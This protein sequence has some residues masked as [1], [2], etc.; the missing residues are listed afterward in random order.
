MY[1]D[2]ATFQS[3]AGFVNVETFESYNLLDSVSALPSLGGTFE[4]FSNGS[5]PAGYDQSTGG[6]AHSGNRTLINNDKLALPGLGSIVFNADLN[7]EFSAFGLWNTGGDDTVRLSIFDVN[8]ILLAST[9]SVLGE[10]FIGITGLSGGVKAE[11][12]AVIGNGWFSI[13]DL[14]TATVPVPGTPVPEPSTMLLLGS[15]LVGL[16]GFNYRRRKQAG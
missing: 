11:I 14:Q 7:K 12:S 2:E 16:I 9:D 13:D 4:T 1:N 5:L 3:A 15:G 6:T 8:N 10:T